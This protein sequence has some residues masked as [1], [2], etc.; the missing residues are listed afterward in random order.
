MKTHILFLGFIAAALVSC[1]SNPALKKTSLG[2]H[3]MIYD[4]DNRPIKEVRVYVGDKLGAESDIH[5]HF[6]LEGLK[7]GRNY[8]IKAFKD[9][10]EEETLDIHY[11]DPKNV[12][13]LNM[14]SRDQLLSR[15]EQALREENQALSASYLARAAALDEDY[16][17]TQYLRAALAF[18]RG[19]YDDALDIL[20]KLN[21]TER[22]APYLWLFI[23]DLCQYFTGDNDRAAV[24]LNKFL[25]QHYDP[26]IAERL[27]T[28]ELFRN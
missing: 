14:N 16:S 10:Y 25:K 6:A 9:N 21:E 24:F 13:Y 4:G 1:A 11:R 27:A 26:E 8:R 23:A 20:L 18:R 5:G 2:L 28:I 3:G 17:P 12:L 19:E 7:P 15:A 22:N